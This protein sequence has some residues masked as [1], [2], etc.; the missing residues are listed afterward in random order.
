M[1]IEKHPLASDRLALPAAEAANLVGVS[2]RHWWSMHATGRLGPMPIALGRSKRWRVDEL[3][4][5]LAAGAPPR[6]KWLSMR[7][8]TS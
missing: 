3:R 4:A 7:G 5:W 6:D 8:E 2:E 1:S